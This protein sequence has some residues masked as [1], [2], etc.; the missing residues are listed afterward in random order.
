MSWGTKLRHGVGAEFKSASWGVFQNCFNFDLNFM[1]F[2][3][4]EVGEF[5]VEVLSYWSWRSSWGL[6]GACLKP[7][8]ICLP[9][10]CTLFNHSTTFKLIHDMISVH[11]CTRDLFDRVKIEKLSTPHRLPNGGMEYVLDSGQLN[12]YNIDECYFLNIKRHESY[13][14]TMKRRIREARM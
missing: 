7:P 6:S 4:S 1:K 5:E 10:L 12:S 9:C 11:W 2:P 3:N 8:I 13:S 14:L